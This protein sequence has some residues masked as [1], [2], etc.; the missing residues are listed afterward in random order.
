MTLHQGV[1]IYN[2]TQHSQSHDYT[3]T[4]QEQAPVGGESH[5]TYIQLLMHSNIRQFLSAITLC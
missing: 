3:N 4:P 2:V 5:I 1:T